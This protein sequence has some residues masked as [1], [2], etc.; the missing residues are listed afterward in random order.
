MS[1]YPLLQGTFYNLR[2]K[3]LWIQPLDLKQGAFYNLG[4]KHSWI[5]MFAGRSTLALNFSLHFLPRE[6]HPS[7]P[8]EATARAS[9]QISGK[10]RASPILPLS[11]SLKSPSKRN[12]NS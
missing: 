11:L 1:L 3:H 10:C 9:A 8:R 12:R 5:M 7:R 4:Y 6:G 2:Y